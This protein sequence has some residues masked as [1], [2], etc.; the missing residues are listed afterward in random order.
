MLS[1][2]IISTL[3]T[4][5]LCV[6]RFLPSCSQRAV[7]V[8]LSVYI[9]LDYCRVSLFDDKPTILQHRVPDHTEC[10]YCLRRGVGVVLRYAHM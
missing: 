4:T 6:M 9:S 5:A 1:A 2:R 10:S 7:H 8:E 3:F